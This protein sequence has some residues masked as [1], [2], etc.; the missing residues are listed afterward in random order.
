MAITSLIIIG[1]SDAAGRSS[2]RFRFPLHERFAS[3]PTFFLPLLFELFLVV[4]DD[5]LRKRQ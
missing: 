5:R 1:E 2:S 3:L 4:R